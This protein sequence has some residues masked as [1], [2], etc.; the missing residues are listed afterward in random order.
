MR[1]HFSCPCPLSTQILHVT[2]SQWHMVIKP[3]KSTTKEMENMMDGTGTCFWRWTIKSNRGNS[4]QNDMT[5]I[6]FSSSNAFI[7]HCPFI[8]PL[9]YFYGK[10]PSSSQNKTHFLGVRD[11]FYIS[12]L[13]MYQIFWGKGIWK[14]Q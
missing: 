8:F 3:V 13:F 1:C 9:L 7:Q 11:D 5:T 4:G 14:V 6:L 12:E 2:C 10:H